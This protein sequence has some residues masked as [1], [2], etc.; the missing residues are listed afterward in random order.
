MSVENLI[1]LR[2][3]LAVTWTAAN[4]I[5]A[6]R[7]VGLETDTR[8]QKVGDGITAWNSLPYFGVS[9]TAFDAALDD[10]ATKIDAAINALVTATPVAS[11]GGAAIQAA[12]RGAWNPTPPFTSSCAATKVKAV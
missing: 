12:V 8:R 5:L 6:L 1:Q 10:I 2:G 3:G 11:D 4:P 9:D 7:E